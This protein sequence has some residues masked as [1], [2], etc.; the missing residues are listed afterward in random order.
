MSNPSAQSKPPQATDDQEIGISEEEK[1][2]LLEQSHRFHDDRERTVDVTSTKNH[3]FD[4]YGLKRNLLRGIYGMGFEK[5]SPVQEATI[6]ISLTGAHILARAKNGTGKTGAFLIPVLE[7]VDP[8]KECIQAVI[9][10]PTRELAIQI[11]QNTSQMAKYLDLRVQMVTGGTPVKDDILALKQPGHILIATIGR[12]YDLADRKIADLSQCKM[13]VMDEADKLVNADF[14][15]TIDG[16]ISFL[17]EQRQILL[18]SATFPREVKSFSDKYMPNSHEVNLM[19]ELTLRG[20]TQFY[21]FVEEKEKLCCLNALFQRLEINQ[22]MIFCNSIPRVVL[23][24]KKITEMGHSCYYMH[25]KMPREQRNR[26]FVD[27]RAGKCRNLVCSDLLTR[28]IDIPSVNVVINFDMPNA[29]E[30][31][32]HRIGRGGRFGHYS[33]AINLITYEDRHKMFQ[34]ERELGT[35]IRPI[36]NVISTELYPAVSSG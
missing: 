35:E 18:F 27:F 4:D 22:A 14:Q 15:Q 28:G 29:S 20:V 31:Y 32:L 10:V 36:P 7:L 16:I 25:S 1:K 19:D 24:A 12:L 30:T 34:I 2:Q 21:A 3:S 5:P 17:P 23:L 33:I 6:P 26:V 8:S 13:L 11:K 9:L